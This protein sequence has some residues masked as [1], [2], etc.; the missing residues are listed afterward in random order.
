MALMKLICLIF[1]IMFAFTFA[2]DKANKPS[3]P[4]I[5]ENVVQSAAQDPNLQTFV[6]ALQAAGLA[7]LLE[8][9]GPYT[10]FAPTNEAFEN[11]G[12]EKLDE[13]LK[14]ENKEKLRAILLYHVVPG[15]ILTNRL[16]T[17]TAQTA[18]GKEL[19]IQ[20]TGS[21]I[22]INGAQIVHGD[23]EASNGVIHVI[24]N[25]LLP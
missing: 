13:L 9:P 21:D 23:M 22:K 19:K 20:V 3:I 10:V 7:S 6:F 12:K 1:T 5:E 14:P 24:N 4:Y 17:M 8:G 2:M 18:N 15:T 11:L 25:V 16:Q